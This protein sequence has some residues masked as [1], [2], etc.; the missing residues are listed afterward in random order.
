MSTGSAD[1]EE[2]VQ[3]VRDSILKTATL[4][5]YI[6]IYIY[7]SYQRTTQ[8]IISEQEV[9]FYKTIVFILSAQLV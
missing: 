5:I 1:F 4:N 7:I 2:M 3:Q 9:L 8:T 6:Y